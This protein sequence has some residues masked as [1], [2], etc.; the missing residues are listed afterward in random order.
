MGASVESGQSDLKA[1]AGWEWA[2]SLPGRVYIGG[3]PPT[4]AGEVNGSCLP[5][6]RHWVPRAKKGDHVSFHPQSSQ[7]WRGVQSVSLSA[8]QR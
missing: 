1:S 2:G 3:P 6:G 5:S 8:L 4:A 7:D